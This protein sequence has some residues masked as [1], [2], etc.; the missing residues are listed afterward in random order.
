MVCF[1]TELSA[2]ALLKIFVLIKFYSGSLTV[3]NILANWM[4]M[5]NGEKII[6]KV[7]FVLFLFNKWHYKKLFIM[8]LFL[9]CFCETKCDHK[10]QVDNWLVA[11]NILNW[12]LNVLKY[13]GN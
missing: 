1:E 6:S 2:H 4:S 7:L 3:L 13:V 5:F 11:N 12:P 9:F 8:A 10:V